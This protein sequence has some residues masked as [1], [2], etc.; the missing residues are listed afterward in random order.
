MLL[1][2]FKVY[3]WWTR[4]G[5]CLVWSKRDLHD[6]LP[7]DMLPWLC[8]F[9]TQIGVYLLDDIGLR[10]FIYCCIHLLL[11]QQYPSVRTHIWVWSILMPII[12]SFPGHG[13][14]CVVRDITV[15]LAQPPLDYNMTHVWI[16]TNF[17]SRS[18][19]L[20]AFFSFIIVVNFNIF[21]F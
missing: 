11:H 20:F 8:T 19:L 21:I 13:P 12:G 4:D 17:L 10:T 2:R 15:Y 5:N 9:N 6:S 3:N 7:G 18:M 14:T 1:Q 16:A